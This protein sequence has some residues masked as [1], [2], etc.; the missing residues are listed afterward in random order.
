MNPRLAETRETHRLY[1]EKLTKL[2]RET[3]DLLMAI[4]AEQGETEKQGVLQV[5]ELMEK[6]RIQGAIEQ[7][8]FLANYAG[9]EAFFQRVC[10][11]LENYQ[12]TLPEQETQ[13]VAI[14]Y[15]LCGTAFIQDILRGEIPEICSRALI[16]LSGRRKGFLL[17]RME[18]TLVTIAKAMEKEGK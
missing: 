11:I 16:F 10:S 18:A 9:N 15:N 5:C 12:E 2:H 17:E 14:A 4:G 6:Y 1:W 3:M 13:A 7:A 8:R